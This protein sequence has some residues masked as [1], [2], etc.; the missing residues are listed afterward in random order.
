MKFPRNRNSEIETEFYEN[1]VIVIES[2]RIK[3]I[4]T[5]VLIRSK[6]RKTSGLRTTATR[7]WFNKTELSL[8]DISAQKQILTKIQG[9]MLLENSTPAEHFNIN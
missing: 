4:T 5:N 3:I 2:I 8:R 9:K 6:C 1:L 7:L